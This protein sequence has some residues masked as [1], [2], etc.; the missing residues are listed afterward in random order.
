MTKPGRRFDI[1]KNGLL[2][3]GVLIVLCAISLWFL[4]WL[5]ISRG[6]V[7]YFTGPSPK[8]GNP[9]HNATDWL[10]LHGGTNRVENPLDRWGHTVDILPSS[11]EIWVREMIFSDRGAQVT[12]SPGWGA[13]VAHTYRTTCR[14]FL[15]LL[16]TAG[17]EIHRYTH[18]Q[19]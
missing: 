16:K 4:S 14:K 15:S 3:T 19:K 2:A 11:Y 8:D 18:K 10:D 17:S 12:V 5:Q 9:F 7:V 6:Q 1:E 13:T